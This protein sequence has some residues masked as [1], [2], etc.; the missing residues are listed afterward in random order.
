MKVSPTS[1]TNSILEAAKTAT[2]RDA[3]EL[4]K[5]NAMLSQFIDIL[6]S[7]VESE[8]IFRVPGNK[9]V[10]TAYLKAYWEDPNHLRLDKLDLGQGKLDTNDTT[11]MLKAAISK[12]SINPDTVDPAV[13]AILL[14]FRE[15]MLAHEE[16]AAEDERILI[17]Q[18][19]EQLIACKAYEEARIFY[20]FMHIGQLI[21]AHEDKNKMSEKNIAIA[22][23]APQFSEIISKLTGVQDEE[24]DPRRAFKQ[25]EKMQNLLQNSFVLDNGQAHFATPF[26]QRFPEA[27]LVCATEAIHTAED[28]E[29]KIAQ[30]KLRIHKII[31]AADQPRPVFDYGQAN[32]FKIPGNLFTQIKEIENELLAAKGPLIE[33]DGKQMR[34]FN[35]DQSFQVH[36]QDLYARGLQ[37]AYAMLKIAGFENTEI[38]QGFIRQCLL[39]Y[40][41]DMGGLTQHTPE[42]FAKARERTLAFVGMMSLTLAEARVAK[43]IPQPSAD[44][45]DELKDQYYQQ[46]FKD[47]KKATELYTMLEPSEESICTVMRKDSVYE[48]QISEKLTFSEATD[49]ELE[50]QKDTAWYKQGQKNHGPWFEQFMAQHLKDVMKC[51]PPCTTR[52]MPNPSNAWQERNIALDASGKILHQEEKI[53]FAISSPFNI[54]DKQARVEMATDGMR[55]LLSEERLKKIAEEYIKRWGP[56]LADGEAININLLHQTLVAP[57]FFYGPDRDMMA[58]K[59]ASNAEVLDYLSGLNIEV[60]GRKINFT[61]GQVN[62][63][64]NM[65]HPVIIPTDNDISDSNQLVA[66]VSSLVAKLAGKVSAK[67]GVTANEIDLVQKFLDNQKRSWLTFG[68]FSQKS[69]TAEQQQAIETLSEKLFQGKLAASG[70]SEESQRDLSLILQAAVNLKKLNHESQFGWAIRKVKNAIRVNEVPILAPVASLITSPVYIGKYLAKT[71]GRLFS[72][73]KEGAPPRLVDALMPTR[74]AQTAKSAYES[75]LCSKLGISMGGCKSAYDREGEA[76]VHRAAMLSQFNE[77]GRVFDASASDR[78][79]YEY[80]EKY[81]KPAE[82]SGHQN[83]VAAH[84]DRTGGRKMWESRTHHYETASKDEKKILRGNATKFRK[85]AKPPT[86]KAKEEMLLEYSPGALKRF[87]VDE[88]DNT[89]AT[90]QSQIGNYCIR[91]G[92]KNVLSQDACEAKVKE[93]LG[94]QGAE[95]LHENVT[96]VETTEAREAFLKYLHDYVLNNPDNRSQT[97][98][99]SQATSMKDFLNEA[100]VKLYEAAIAEERNSV[101]FRNAVFLKSTKHYDGAKWDKRLVLWVGGPSASG[102]SFGADG[103]VQRL[104]DEIMGHSSSDRSGNNVVSVD[105]GIERDVSQMRQ[106]VLQVALSK[107]FKGIDDL[108]SYTKLGTKKHVQRAAFATTD[109]SVVLPNTFSSS[110]VT[111]VKAKMTKIAKM[112]NTVQVFCDV[113]AEKGQSRRFERSVGLMGNSRAWYQGKKAYAREKITMLEPNTGAES[114]RYEGGIKFFTGLIASDRAKKSYIEACKETGNQPIRMVITN[115]LIFLKL[116][117]KQKWVECGDK[118]NMAALSDFVKMSA[119]DFAAWQSF[120]P[121]QTI[122]N[123]NTLQPD[124]ALELSRLK[125]QN[126][127]KSWVKY[128]QLH[129]LLSPARVSYTH[130]QP[131][132]AR[133]AASAITPRYQNPAHPEFV[134]SKQERH[135]RSGTWPMP[136]RR[137]SQS[138]EPSGVV[139]GSSLQSTPIDSNLPRTSKSAVLQSQSTTVR[140]DMLHNFSHTKT[141]PMQEI[142]EQPVKYALLKSHL[143]DSRNQER[144]GISNFSEQKIA[145]KSTMVLAFDTAKPAEKIMGYGI[146]GPDENVAFALQKNLTKDNRDSGIRRLCQIAVDAAMPG[147]EFNLAHSPQDKRELIAEIF[148]ELLEQAVREKR[149]TAEDCPR[150]I[151]HDLKTKKVHSSPLGN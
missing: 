12:L 7:C 39:K 119:R 22:L 135:V 111:G 43:I 110:I 1:K 129:N 18:L 142:I 23:L 118:E 103:V 146:K 78:K 108:H 73:F 137:E 89:L 19:I 32:I 145:N 30:D 104:N 70:L 114:K 6:P 76:N 15:K 133:R 105:G 60:D 66:H 139:D 150:L 96:P 3:T 123:T 143:Q 72:H 140:H 64:I 49:A 8:G 40:T 121:G 77:S 5:L 100:G 81:V 44:V 124:K 127:L 59:K 126:D 99:N 36:T 82:E 68:P 28:T 101:A 31:M 9:E 148:T 132:R 65:W 48:L 41:E 58:V 116:D 97:L 90:W 33:I 27:A 115:D 61:L 75:I 50:K 144:Y 74:N 71:A 21:A 35:G 128:C 29:M 51:S 107:G 125:E 95:I 83:Y 26:E 25:T 109:L 79:Y 131:T 130:G 94:E 98:V 13:K 88:E 10:I 11:G 86:K 117:K 42:H 45:L 138:L 151:N 34:V 147:D 24:K 113:Q 54:K 47:L 63:C 38:D 20:Q 92:S 80:L 91:D 85:I 102:K 93:L 16:N 53:R 149:F 2:L 141:V 122:L 106:M 134:P 17:H 55:K 46:A 62:N 37:H 14:N 67:D 52:D 57:T 56:L 4:Q 120:V 69:P 112:P 87:K 84:V 136:S